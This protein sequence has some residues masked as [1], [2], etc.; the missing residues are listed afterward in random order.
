VIKSRF[1]IGVLISLVTC[2][3]GCAPT[4][5][6]DNIFVYNESNGISSL[7]PAYARDIEIMWATNQLFDGLVELND[8]M[9]IQPCIAKSFHISENKLLYT[10]NIRGDVY[11][12]DAVCFP[13]GIG[14]QCIAQDF[15]YSFQRI[16]NSSTASPGKWIF[17]KVK[18][19]GFSALNDTTL[20]IELVEPFAP[21]LGL[22]TTQYANVIPSEAVEYYGSD[23][24]RNPVGTGPFQFAYWYDDIALIFHK[25]KK[26]FM[27]D[28]EGKQ[29][30]YL[31]GVKIEFVKDMSAEYLGLMQGKYDF[32]SGV[33]A[34]FKDELLQ[35]NGELLP[36]VSEK[37]YLQKTPFIKTDYLG[38]V[39]DPTL[40][41][42][43][44]LLNPL[45]R[46][47]MDLSIDKEKMV[48]HLRNN[49][50]IAANS[51]FCSPAVGMQIN[52][53][54]RSKYNVREAEKLLEQAGY[55]KGNGIEKIQLA[56]TSDYADLME[57]IQHEWQ[58]VGIACEVTVLQ[59]SSFS[60]AAGK[61][62]LQ[63]FR[64]SWLADH[65]HPE[66][67]YSLYNSNYFAPNGPNYTHFK[68][69]EFDQLYKKISQTIIPDSLYF[70][71]NKM[72]TILM[73]DMPIIPLFYDQVMHFI[74]NR[75][76]NFST[77]SVNM[78]DLRRVRKK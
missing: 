74:S 36:R 66:N 63:V 20:Q 75:V 37:I 40:Q 52:S 26:Y 16:I 56:T 45:V 12:H 67:F 48:K 19:N 62:Q 34:A 18:A 54:N 31:D 30:P 41:T 64:K 24:T 9:Q 15:V 25:N 73:N 47:A 43:K 17:D 70:F 53:Q 21:F 68:N 3:A 33:T 38:I 78:L 69:N 55:P 35:T 61:C 23:F 58:L 39:V 5:S 4:T 29:L 2:L 11:F 77:N 59:K 42:N 28:S 32:M 71:S 8:S 10:F 51:G 49:T 7:D 72:E 44:A 46:K 65:T 76:S 22:L 60:E 27:R 14:R 13:N 6:H 50:V 1:Y 57:F